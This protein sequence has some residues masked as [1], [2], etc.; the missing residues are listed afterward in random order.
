M[1]IS[2]V[3]VR[4]TKRDTSSHGSSSNLFG[5]MHVTVRQLDKVVQP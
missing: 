5:A 1:Y 2:Y 3:E 4:P